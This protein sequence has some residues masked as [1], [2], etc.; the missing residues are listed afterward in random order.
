[1]VIAGVLA[2]SVGMVSYGAASADRYTS[3][4]YTIDASVGNTFGGSNSSTSYKLV[5]S[6]GE[7]IIGGGAGGSYILGAGYVAQLDKSIQLTVQPK[8][9]VSYT[10]LDET[11]PTTAFDASTNSN[12]GSAVNGPT[13]TTGQVGGAWNFDGVDDKIY[14]GAPSALNTLTSFTWSYWVYPT[15]VTK[16]QMFASKQ[17]ANY[18]RITTS[19]AFL[20]VYDNGVQRTLSGTSTLNNNQWYLITGT[21]AVGS[22]KLYVNG[23]E[24]ASRSDTTGPLN[25][26]TGPYEIGQWSDVD[27][28]SFVGKIDEGKIFNRQLSAT[29]VKAEYDAG[30]AGN[31]AGLSFPSSIVA[32]TSQTTAADAVIQT[33]APGY[34]FMINQNNNLTSGAN[35][36]PVVSN[37]G[38]IASPLTWTESTT[39]GLGFTLTSTSATA[40]PG[41]WGTN[42]NYAYAAVPNAATSA[43]VRTGYT[44]GGKDT[45]GIQYRLDVA[46]SQI[47]GNY[48]NVVTYT[49]V[50][51]P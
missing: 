1:M 51:T 32:G 43:Y 8:G 21:Y 14:V 25:F 2:L 17:S 24:E 38:T 22:M 29:E 20:S 35:T 42:P 26:N 37:G 46:T 30:V 16:D 19:K 3:T 50:M 6:G 10:P 41:K 45:L 4:S 33:D 48:T 40:L 9:L 15:S 49:G 18:M 27:K 44:A 11:T 12:N 31:A 39:K 47:S 23:V 13:V 5:G 28:R 36:I 34:T 7:S